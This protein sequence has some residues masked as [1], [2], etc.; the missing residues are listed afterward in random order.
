MDFKSSLTKGT[1]P[2]LLLEILS[3]G[4]AYGYELCKDI[5]SRSDGALKFGQG[6]V[7]P[8]LYKLE[9]KGWVVS[10]RK[11]TP[12]GKERRY[13]KLTDAGAKHLERCKKTWFETSAAIGR[14]LGANPIAQTCFG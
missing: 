11:S 14:I 7:Y 4:E 6:T 2:I 1:V 10:E 13:Y 12:G 8:L 5:A 9:E 3:E